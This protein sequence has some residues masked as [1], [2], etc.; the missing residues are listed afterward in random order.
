MNFL[1]GRVPGNGDAHLE[2]AGVSLPLPAAGRRIL[3]DYHGRTILLGLRAEDV[4]LDP[5]GDVSARVRLVEPTGGESYVYGRIG[6]SRIVARGSATT[7][8]DVD[9]PV[10][11][12]FDLEQAHF[13][14]PATDERIGG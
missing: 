14:D 7:R 3:K 12:R 11:L 10:R 5:A 2:V 8:L 6:E 4:H 13:F 9:E 1:E